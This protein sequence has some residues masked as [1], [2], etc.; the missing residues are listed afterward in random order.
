MREPTFFAPAFIFG[1]GV[2]VGGII[3]GGVGGEERGE[4][5]GEGLFVTVT[6][7]LRFVTLCDALL[8]RYRS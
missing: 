2:W 7:L 1:V 4:G 8:F 6:S 5:K 3:G